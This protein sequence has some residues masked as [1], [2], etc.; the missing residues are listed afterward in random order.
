VVPARYFLTA[1][2]GIVLKGA[3]ISHLLIPLAA[4]TVYAAAMLGLASM[5]LAKSREA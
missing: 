1:L 2:R 3:P 5:R 4:L